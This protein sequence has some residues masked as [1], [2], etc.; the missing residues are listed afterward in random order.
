[1][2]NVHRIS[3]RNRSDQGSIYISEKW[4]KLSESTGI[5]ICLPVVR[6]Q[7]L[8]YI[9]ERLHELLRRISNKVKIDIPT[10]NN[11]TLL[12]IAVKAMNNTIEKKG[13]VRSRLVFGI[14]PRLSII[15][16]N[17]LKQKEIMEVIVKVQIEMNAIVAEHRTKTALL[18]NIPQYAYH[19]FRIGDRALV[20]SENHD[21]F[22]GPF[23]VT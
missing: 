14:F 7:S 11:N 12:K 10:V 9:G 21:K 3:N 8:L 23:K 13:L 17:F 1:M 18:R 2:S 22:I 4:K 5:E 20:Y 16:S 19:A 6:A 15:A